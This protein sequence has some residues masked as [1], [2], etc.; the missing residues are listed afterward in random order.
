MILTYR[1]RVKGALNARVLAKMTRSAN[2]VWNYCGE[3]QNHA[4]L[5]GT[6]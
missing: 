5:W 4:R 2:A 6:A 3:V 1:Y